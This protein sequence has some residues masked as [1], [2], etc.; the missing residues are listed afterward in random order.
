SDGL[1]VASCG[2]KVA[3]WR[4]S[5]VSA[6]T[7][8][9]WRKASSWFMR[10]DYGSLNLPLRLLPSHGPFRVVRT[11]TLAARGLVNGLGHEFG[12]R[13]AQRPAEVPMAR[14][15]ENIQAAATAHARHHV[16]HHG[17]QARPGRVLARADPGKAIV[18]P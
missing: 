18:H 9:C 5:P 14:V 7:T 1:V 15:V 6:T 10:A 8:V 13:R 16:R 3:S 12:R 17:P 2:R 4:K 11:R